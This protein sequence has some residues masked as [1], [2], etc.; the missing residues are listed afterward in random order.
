LRLAKSALGRKYGL[1]KQLTQNV[2]IPESIAIQ[3][4]PQSHIG[5]IMG[6]IATRINTHLGFVLDQQPDKSERPRPLDRTKLT[7]ETGTALIRLRQT[8]AGCVGVRS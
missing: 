3:N 6:A 7:N 5:Y 8:S 1:V 4:T 2:S